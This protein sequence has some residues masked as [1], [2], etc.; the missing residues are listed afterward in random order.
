M[1][2]GLTISSKEWIDEAA[3]IRAA[4]HALCR[5][6]LLGEHAVQAAREGRPGKPVLVERLDKAGVGYYLIP[7]NTALGTELIVRVDAST[8]KLLGVVQIVEPT[9]SHFLSARE[10][11]VRA[12]AELPGVE[13]GLPRCSW[14]PCRQS[15]TPIRPFYEFPFE[16]G[17]L[18][19]DVDGVVY[20]KLTP[21]GRGG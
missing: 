17:A 8:G 11:L 20:R 21:L 13:F 9:A 19:V 12:R 1:H 6:E 18:Y 3:A 4:K 14:F 10:A 2:G 15:T 7:W 5:Q 16:D